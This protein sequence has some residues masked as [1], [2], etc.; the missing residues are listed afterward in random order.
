M[1]PKQGG[2]RRPAGI[3][4]PFAV[5]RYQ[6]E[7]LTP[8]FPPEP[9]VFFGPSP[10][11][12]P[13]W[14]WAIRA[15]FAIVAH[16]PSAGRPSPS[17]DPGASTPCHD[18]PARRPG[19]AGASTTGPTRPS[20]PSSWR[21]CCRSISPPWSPPAGP[22]APLRWFRAHAGHRPLGLCHLPLH[23]LVALAA[24]DLGA[25]A[26]RRGCAAGCSSASACSAAVATAL[27]WPRRPGALSAGRPALR[28]R[29][30]GFAA[31]NIF[32]NAFLP[33]LASGPELDR[34]S[35]RG[36]ALGY[37]GGGLA[38]GLSSLIILFTGPLRLR[39]PR[40]RHPRR[41]PADRAVVGRLRPADLRLRARGGLVRATRRPWSGAC[42][43]ICAPSPKCAATATCSLFLLA[44]LFYNDGIQTVIAVSA[45][46][47][48]EELALSRGRSSAPS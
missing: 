11:P 46:F 40:R 30:L 39:R 35:A 26:D 6:H 34:L 12:R 1:P 15:G 5:N 16:C 27:L 33:A 48:R 7:F 43:A 45:I 47:G 23:A 42:A 10:P 8:C 36:F 20:P 17:P 37:I 14:P 22:A 41:I 44:F 25:L 29:Q 9:G 3:G 21:R 38:A 31:G 4:T 28:H 32:Y 24:P 2:A 19:S 13:D 18:P